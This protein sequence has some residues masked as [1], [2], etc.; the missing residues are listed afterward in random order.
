[1][2]TAP[3]IEQRLAE[4]ES[5]L[6]I[7]QL[8]A[9]YSFAVDDRDIDTMGELFTE[10]AFFGSIDK[11]MGARGRDAILKQFEGRFSI[12][13]PGNHFTHN[14][15]LEF[16]SPTRAHGVVSAHAELF[17]NDKAMVTAFRYN[18]VYEKSDG[19]WRFAERLLSFFYYLDVRDYASTLG[20]L[21][22]NRAYDKPLPADFPEALPSWKLYHK[23]V[24]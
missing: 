19:A 16:D 4:V 2:N 7:A 15:T 18:D 23:E 17:R 3:S 20:K 8:I 21:D 1:M 22:R 10:D 9:K 12:L 6:A 13:G 5:R 24:G 11:V 14:H